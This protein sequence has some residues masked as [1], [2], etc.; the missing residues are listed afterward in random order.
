MD[1]FRWH[2][3]L[4]LDAVVV[5]VAFKARLAGAQGSVL[6]GTA[7]G[8]LA[9]RVLHEARVGALGV[10]ARL[11]KCAIRVAPT[12]Q[13]A[14]SALAYLARVARGIRGAAVHHAHVVAAHK[15]CGTGF[16]RAA[17]GGG[18]FRRVT[19]AH[20]GISYAVSGTGAHGTV[21]V[22]AAEGVDAA[23]PP[24]AARVAALPFSARFVERTVLVRSA[25]GY[26]AVA[27]ADPLQA[28]VR[29]GVALDGDFSAV[30]FGVSFEAGR[31]AALWRVADGHAV[32]VESA[33]SG[34]A[35]V[36]TNSVAAFQE[37][38]AIAVTAAASH[39]SSVFAY[40][41]AIAVVVRC[42]QVG[43]RTPSAKADEPRQA[44]FVHSTLLTLLALELRVPVKSRR[45]EAVRTMSFRG[46]VGVDAARTSD[47]AGVLTLGPVAGPVDGAVLVA[48]AA[49]VAAVGL[50]DSSQT[51]VAVRPALDFGDASPIFARP[52][53]AAF[54]LS[55]A[56]VR[57]PK[58][59]HERIA[60]GVRRAGA[61]E[62][63][64]DGLALCTESAGP[65]KLARVLALSAD[66]RLVVWAAGIRT[67]TLHASVV[68][69]DVAN[70]ALRVDDAL[71]FGA[72]H[73]GIPR[74]AG[75]AAAV[76]SMVHRLALGVWS[77]RRGASA[78]I[79]AATVDA[80][81]RRRAVEVRAAAHEAQSLLTNM[82][83]RAQ[84]IGRAD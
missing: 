15:I 58:A 54:G 78:R 56:H 76:R 17:L 43:R 22:G 28:A 37:E 29:I 34:P 7:V 53:G 13:D 73:V 71:H 60:H 16:V 1:A 46:T 27:D 79:D 21:V 62:T 6:Y 24:L 65:H 26:A 51:A 70:R 50:A 55:A 12:S 47:A 80:G 48:A 5:G 44:L 69:A 8:I 19:A 3:H 72:L 63:V 49:I 81:V 40:F 83:S 75:T 42:A 20:L 59:L 11:V 2:D 30:H 35:G 45:T 82:I 68:L 10:D 39:A 84:G 4:D 18:R 61:S 36:L 33:S 77:T 23:A 52:F 57:V 74:V 31:T 14:F 66:A 38:V 64:V 9:A 25:P 32:G 67:T 41:P